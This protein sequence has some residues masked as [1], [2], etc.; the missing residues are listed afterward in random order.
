MYDTKPIAICSNHSNISSVIPNHATTNL[1]VTM[2][3][4]LG[5]MD[6]QNRTPAEVTKFF[7]QLSKQPEYRRVTFIKF[8]MIKLAVSDSSVHIL[9][10]P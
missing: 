10:H 3:C 1:K 4:G 7:S 8:D 9:F 6:V 2:D 5:T